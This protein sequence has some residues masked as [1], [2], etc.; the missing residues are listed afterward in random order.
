M[1]GTS[2][3]DV[4][5]VAGE[6]YM[7]QQRGEP[8]ITVWDEKTGKLL[9]SWGNPPV[10]DTPHALRIKKAD[11]SGSGEIEI[12]ITDMGVGL[13]DTGHVIKA[14]TP[15]GTLLRTI[16]EVGVAGTGLR[17]L[18][19]GNVADLDWSQDFT[20]MVIVDGD[21]G[22]NNRAVEISAKNGDVI[23]SWG[24]LGGPETKGKFNISHGVAI[25]SCD[26]VWVADRANARVQ[27][28]TL[29]GKW[30]ATW[31][32]MN[33]PPYGVRMFGDNEQQQLGLSSAAAAG[34]GHVLVTGGGGGVGGTPTLN[35]LEILSFDTSCTAPLGECVVDYTI[36]AD[37]KSTAH[38]SALNEKTKDI[39]L[40]EVTTNKFKKYT[41]AASEDEADR[42][43]L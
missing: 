19:F 42:T 24:G 15:N 33:E 8:R 38:F 1:N 32:C 7:C 34:Q 5:P 41:Y 16:G 25:D 13:P 37:P 18:Q 2:G 17:P 35:K 23:T 30:L 3:V 43:I 26:R 29:A 14:F 36:V 4:D 27:I 12:W 39:Y 11:I 6:V 21:G 28:F 40:C 20:K 10:L 31:T 9:R 22:P